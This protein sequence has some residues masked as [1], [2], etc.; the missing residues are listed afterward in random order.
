MATNNEIQR[1]PFADRSSSSSF[2]RANSYL[3]PGLRIKGEVTGNEDLTLDSDVE[4]L[5]SIGGFRLTVGSKAKLEGDVV[6]REAMISGQVVGNI[7]ASDRVEVMKSA[8]I[9]GDVSTGRIVIEEG[10]YFSG[11]LVVDS[12]NQ[13]I[14]TDLDTLLKGTHKGDGK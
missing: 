11:D 14:G 12:R 13:R 7:S 1:G 5:V 8:S 2:G 3:G 9:E 6:A 4:G 10:A